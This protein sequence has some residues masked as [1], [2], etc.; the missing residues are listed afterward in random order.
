MSSEV[1]AHR[2]VI[3]VGELNPFGAD[4]LLALYHLPRGSS[5]NRLRVILGLTDAEY[6]RIPKV[7]LCEGKWSTRAAHDRARGLLADPETRVYVLLGRRVRDAFRAACGVAGLLADFST[8]RDSGNV[9]YSLA[10]LP[11]TSG[12]CRAWNDP[13]AAGRARDLLRGCAPEIPWGSVRESS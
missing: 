12:L 2:K 5:G 1:N 11:H 7:N 4:P 8:Y 10:D 13:A 6:A 9:A 3:L